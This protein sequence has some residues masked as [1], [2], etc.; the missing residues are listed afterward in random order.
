[1]KLV[2]TRKAK[3]QLYKCMRSEQTQTPLS[4]LLIYAKWWWQW[5]RRCM[6]L[7][8]PDD[9]STHSNSSNFPALKP[10]TRPELYNMY[11]TS[12]FVPTLGHSVWDYSRYVLSLSPSL[13]CFSKPP[14][15]NL[16]NPLLHWQPLF[17]YQDQPSF[18][19]LAAR[20][21]QRTAVVPSQ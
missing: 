4:F 16:P 20:G 21:S 2:K 12:S 15:P 10:P 6:T 14:A 13:L 7:A 19:G 17:L 9:T 1:M 3:S 8:K 18:C 11:V 5:W